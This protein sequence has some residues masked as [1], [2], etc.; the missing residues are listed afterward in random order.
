MAQVVSQQVLPGHGSDQ[1]DAGDKA[2]GM[3][4]ESHPAAGI[5]QCGYSRS[6]LQEKPIAEHRESGNGEGGRVKAKE[7]EGDDAGVRIQTGVAPH[8]AA[9]GA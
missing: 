6:Q 3:G 2:S 7:K 8:H 5:L 9:N 1:K 4:P